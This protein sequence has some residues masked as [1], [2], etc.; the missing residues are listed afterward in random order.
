MGEI[1]TFFSVFLAIAASVATI[2]AA[3]AAVEHVAAKARK[4]HH[5]LEIEVEKQGKRLE[6]HDQL[7]DND[8]R[9][10][11]DVEATNRLIM[12]GIMYLLSHEIDGNHAN[13]LKQ[14]RDEMYGYLYDK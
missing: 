3:I 8:N 12:R 5:E 7:L 11:K 13:Q 4:P 6:K 14:V 1:Q 10:L 2:G 9:R